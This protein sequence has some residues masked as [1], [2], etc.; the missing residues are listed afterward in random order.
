MPR[1]NFPITEHQQ[2]KEPWSSQ[3]RYLGMTH[4]GMHKFRE[5]GGNIELFARRK[6]PPAGWYLKRGSYTFEFVSSRDE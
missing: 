5:P 3:Y 6:S 2:G 4:D 1:M